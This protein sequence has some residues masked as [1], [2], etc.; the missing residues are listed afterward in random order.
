[1]AAQRPP[2]EHLQALPAARHPA[3]N[4]NA[5]PRSFFDRGQ[6]DSGQMTVETTKT[7]NQ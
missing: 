1:V 5:T 6:L 2:D 4:T 3:G 7:K